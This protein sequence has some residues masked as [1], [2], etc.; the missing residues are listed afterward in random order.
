MTADAA[1]G[2]QELA[3][4]NE[5]LAILNSITAAL[6]EEVD[7][8]AAL[9]TALNKVADLLQLRTGWIWLLAEDS[10]ERSYLAAAQNLP[11]ALRDNPHRMEGSCYCLRTFRSGDLSGAAN[12]NVVGCS[13]LSELVDGTDGL[14]Y[15]T[16]VPLYASHGKK[17]G[18][19]NVADT[20]WR[21]LSGADLRLLHTIGDLLSMTIERAR[22]FT[23]SRQI[24]AAEERGRLAREIHDTLGQNLAAITLQMETADALFESGADPDQVW[25]IVRKTLALSRSGLQEARRSVLDLRAVPL[26]GRSVFEA[27]EQLVSDF[28]QQ[29]GLAAV[30]LTAGADF[31]V[32]ARVEVAVYRIAQEALANIERHASAASVKVKLTAAPG[33]LRLGVLDDGC[34]FQPDS[35]PRGHYG[36]AGINERVHLLGGRLDLQSSP[37]SGTQ[38]WVTIPLNGGDG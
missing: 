34:G 33:E 28:R 10:E 17:L 8:T 13:R 5:E 20:D 4:R 19:L 15:H 11:P 27:V 38:L 16:S 9:Q 6:N 26:E 22:L 25:E 2:A 21:E 14:R 24:G 30:Y 23:R 12:I 3:R 29:S 36:L 7:L 18:V 32:P 31:P 1:N 37:G 35:I